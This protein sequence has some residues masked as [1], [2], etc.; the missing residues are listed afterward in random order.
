LYRFNV[1]RKDNATYPQT[2]T[3]N[4]WGY[5]GTAFNGTGS[6]WDGG[7]FNGTDTTLGY[8]VL[9]QPGRGQGDLL[10]GDHPNK[11]NVRTGTIGWPAQALEP[12]YIW[13]NSGTIVVGWGGAEYSNVSGG[14][15]VANRD[16]YPPASAIQ[17]SPTSPFDGTS[18]TGWGTLANRPT[19]CT[20]GVAY[21]ATDQGSW[22]KSTSNPY[23]V[24]QN[25]ADG[26]LYKCTAPNTW[27]LY[28]TPHTYPHP[29]QTGGLASGQPSP[30]AGLR[31]VTTGD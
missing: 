31:I 20:P 30:P 15:V 2:A 19:T 12:I 23:G 24:Q 28:Y 17:A 7:T 22:N 25:G 9:D 18:G 1:T 16:Y 8:P 13:N 11:V 3:L 5:A 10:T 27:T 4:G 26:V 29:L 21:F 14:R 6:R